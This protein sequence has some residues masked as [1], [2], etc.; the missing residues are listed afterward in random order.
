M[1]W[2]YDRLSRCAEKGKFRKNLLDVL[3]YC[4]IEE[5]SVFRIPIFRGVERILIFAFPYIQS[6]SGSIEPKKRE[7]NIVLPFRVNVILFL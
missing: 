7:T 4:T 5:Y 3:T 1:G 2:F 6:L